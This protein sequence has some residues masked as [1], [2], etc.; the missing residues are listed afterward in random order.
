MAKDGVKKVKVTKT[1]TKVVESSDDSSSE[2]VPVIANKG[3][4]TTKA[5]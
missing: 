4:T 3:K 2:D 1:I 5:N